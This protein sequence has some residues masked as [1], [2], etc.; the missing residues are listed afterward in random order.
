MITF[1]IVVKKSLETSTT[2]NARC[3]LWARLRE[4]EVA[5]ALFKLGNTATG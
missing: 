1:D 2:E 3:T 4:G 5:L